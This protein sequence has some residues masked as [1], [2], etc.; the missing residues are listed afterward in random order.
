MSSTGKGHDYLGA[1]NG[2]PKGPIGKSRLGGDRTP[3]QK[4]RRVDSDAGASIVS[5]VIDI[6]GDKSKTS[7]DQYVCW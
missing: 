1:V 6:F 5:N 4:A 7:A 2:T 3:P